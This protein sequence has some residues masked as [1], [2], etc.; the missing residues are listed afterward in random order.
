MQKQP[1][2]DANTLRKEPDVN[3]SSLATLRAYM[4]EL[5]I[6]SVAQ[7]MGVPR[8]LLYRHVEAAKKPGD[9]G[10]ID[11]EAIEQGAK[12]DV[13]RAGAAWDRIGSSDLHQY[14]QAINILGGYVRR[15]PGVRIARV[16]TDRQG[17]CFG[18]ALRV[19][20]EPE[21]DPGRPE[22]TLFSEFRDLAA[23]VEAR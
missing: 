6:D 21:G 20:W 23:W 12:V 16:D 11:R 15:K 7:A 14:A 22:Q 10:C 13:V 8:D 19:V 1:Y 4:G 3:T 2:F 17:D 18:V 5:I 9:T